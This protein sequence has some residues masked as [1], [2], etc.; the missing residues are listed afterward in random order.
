GRRRRNG[1]RAEHLAT[2]RSTEVRKR[3]RGGK[4]VREGGALVQNSR[5]PKPA[6]LTRSA[7]R[8][9]MAT[10]GPGPMYGIA[11]LNRNRRRDE[12]EAAIPDRNHRGSCVGRPR[13]EREKEP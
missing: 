1:H 8:A 4:R 13:T 3:S 12:K 2:M 11:G 9:A 10:G 7:R 6:G 5:I